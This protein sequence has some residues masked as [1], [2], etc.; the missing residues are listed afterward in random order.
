MQSSSSSSSS[1]LGEH[2]IEKH[3]THLADLT[4][5]ISELHGKFL[6]RVERSIQVSKNFENA[7]ADNENEK[8]GDESGTRTY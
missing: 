5:K 2:T 8:R 3:L 6:K 1:T 4:A 7:T